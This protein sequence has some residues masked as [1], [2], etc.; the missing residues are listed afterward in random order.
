MEFNPNFA[1]IFYEPYKL[2]YHLNTGIASM[3]PTCA[4]IC[5]YVLCRYWF[6]NQLT[7][8]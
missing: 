1:Y 2:Y 4:W 7:S 5:N 3:N 8:Q 6:Y